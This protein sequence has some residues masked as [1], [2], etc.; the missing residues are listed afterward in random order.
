MPETKRTPLPHLNHFYPTVA[1]VVTVRCGDRLNAM[2]CAWHSALSF[3][4]P[5]YGVLISPKRFSYSL[6]IEAGAFAVNFLPFEKAELIA[7][8]G[9]NSG[10][11]MDKFARFG[12]AVRPV[13][14]ALAPILQEAYAAYE[15]RLVA[16]HTCGDHDLF[17]GEIVRSHVDKRAFGEES[18]LDVGRVRPALYLGADRYVTTSNAPPR[19]LPGR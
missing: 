17:V 18:V 2:A 14:D 12:I 4:P 9:R 6:I 7:A 15:C 13:P 3:R 11:D 1:A 8:V 10:R 5:L 19:H 16:R